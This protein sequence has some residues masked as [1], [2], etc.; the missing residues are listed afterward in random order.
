MCYL[1]PA[2]HVAAFTSFPTATSKEV[3]KAA[4]FPFCFAA[5][6][7]AVIIPIAISIMPAAGGVFLGWCDTGDTELRSFGVNESICIDGQIEFIREAGCEVPDVFFSFA[8]IYIVPAG[9]V[10]GAQLQDVSGIPNTVMGATGG[11][12]SETIGFSNNVGAGTFAIVFDECQDGR[13]DPDV[14]LLMDPAF[15]VVLP[16]VIPPLPESVQAIKSSAAVLANRT[17]QTT[18]LWNILHNVLEG[19]DIKELLDDP[20]ALRNFVR[21]VFE[22]YRQNVTDRGCLEHFLDPFGDVIHNPPSVSNFLDVPIC[23]ANIALANTYLHYLGIAADPPDPNFQQL[24]PVVGLGIVNPNGNDAVLGAFARSGTHLVTEDALARAFLAS[25]ERYQGASA[26]G[27]ATWALIHARASRAY[28]ERLIAHLNATNGPLD[29]LQSAV[30]NDPAPLDTIATKLEAYRQELAIHG[31]SA[32]E[33]RDLRNLG[34]NNT[35]ISGLLQELL[36]MEFGLFTKAGHSATI[37]A[38]QAPRSGMAATLANFVGQMGDLITAMEND[39]AFPDATPIANPGGPYAAPEG[40]VLV[41]NGTGSTSPS[42]LVQY[43][44][45]LNGDGQFGDVTGPQPTVIFPNAFE[46]LVGLRVVNE[47]GLANIAYAVVSISDVNLQPT[48]VAA[49]PDAPSVEVIV[50]TPQLFSASTMDPEGQPVNV[51][52]FIS[53]KP[54]GLGNVFTYAPTGTDVGSA[55]LDVVATDTSPSGGFVHRRWLLVTLMPDADGDGWNTNVDCDDENPVVNPGATEITGNGVDDDCNP[56]TSDVPPPNRP[57]VSN[58]G[59]PYSSSPICRGV[60]TSIPLDGTGSFDP[61][62]DALAYAWTTNCAGVTIDDMHSAKPT[63]TVV[64]GSCLQNCRVT[65][66]VSDSHFPPVSSN[67]VVDC[68]DSVIVFG[69]DFERGFTPAFSGAGT[70]EGV[71]GFTGVGITPNVFGGVFLRNA[72]GNNAEGGSPP[73]RTTLTLT[74]LPPHSGVSLRFLL[75]IINSWDGTGCVSGPDAFNVTVDGSVVFSEVFENSSCGTQSYVSPPKVE[76][77]RQLGLFGRDGGFFNDSAY[78]MGQDPTFNNIPHSSDTLIIEWFA[79][80]PGWQ[81]GDDES[82]AIDNVEVSVF[83]LCTLPPPIPVSASSRKV[84]GKAGTFDI[85]LPLTGTPGI[86][87]RTGGISGD[88]KVIFNFA[89]PVTLNSATITSGTGSVNS[90]AVAGSDVTVDLTGVSNAQTIVIT[91]ADV[92]NSSVTNNVTVSMNVLT[93]DTNGNGM[94]NSV[95]VSQVK[96]QS[97]QPITINNFRTDVNANGTINA[98]D[99]SLVKAKSGTGLP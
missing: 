58:A 22:A 3:R 82:W 68:I 39:P 23:G 97:G 89:S 56:L 37:D 98:S 55:V 57:P 41:L 20:E 10:A 91:L 90:F 60:S 77:A 15:N 67:A 80:G 19:I 78:D 54:V 24:T 47:A 12:F 61:D 42:A 13:Y 36:D 11:F 1:T 75:A 18:R 72:T 7:A 69:T 65:L 16:A 96:S 8:D 46:G 31:F 21:D 5:R 27:N 63:L 32:D 49:L 2:S 44:W 74:G 84:H 99:V 17:A 6:L 62:S 45:D 40:T 43:E 64:D 26:A 76:L 4:V 73:S 28:A 14:D 71:Q 38:F 53:G 35:E 51:S 59:G 86:E 92:S 94:A 95:D 85:N 88:Y 83:G 66:T 48:I 50:G 79:S 29:D 52:W 81:G 9:V 87:C 34:V 70:L 93:G 25:L 30:A 33:L